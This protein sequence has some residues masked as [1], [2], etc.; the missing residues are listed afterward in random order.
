MSADIN[1]IDT[2][3][4]LVESQVIA[5]YE[6]I[7]DK[8]LFPGD[9]VRLFLSSLAS[10]IVQQRVI[11]NNT[12]KQTLLRYAADLVLDE[13][14]DR[15][16]TERLS[17]QNAIVTVRFL[18]SS[19]QPSIVPIA[20][21]TRVSPGNNLF[22]ATM[23]YA[24][25]SPGNTYID[26]ICACLS[27]GTIGNGF[28]AGQI[29][30]LVDPIA[31][32]TSVTNIETSKGGTEKEDDDTYRERI[33][34]APESF[35]VAGPE[36]AYI[37]LAKSANTGIIDVHVHSPSDAVVEIIPLMT[38]GELPTQSVLDQ[39]LS[40]CSAKTK[41]P[42]TDF[43]RVALP[44][45]DIYSIDLTYWI[46]ED[47]GDRST[48]IQSS[49]NAA[50]EDYKTWQRSKLGRDIN[51]DEL[52]RRIL[53]AGAKRVQINSPA[54]NKLEKTEKATDQGPHNIVFGGV[55]A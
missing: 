42:L 3:A 19:V 40:T 11:M 51:P 39:V 20:A 50:I 44:V 27:P 52:S 41:R 22:F 55:E 47:D 8:N 36:G 16:E 10:I 2:S 34:S 26:V 45:E 38:G 4:D 17:A 12:A 14:G 6:A 31:F 48:I 13:F 1:F 15:S 18:L 54:F 29:N 53:N 21:G 5:V 46:D 28:L 37:A 49:V 30:I 9:P 7:I 35:S 24:Q 43:V 23:Q 32:I 33:R 25:I